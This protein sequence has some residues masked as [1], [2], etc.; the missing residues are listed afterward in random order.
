M[1]QSKL[2]KPRQLDKGP[3]FFN[4][5]DFAAKDLK[6]LRHPHGSST[7]F[8]SGCL[9]MA[10]AKNLI[11]AHPLQ[12]QTGLVCQPLSLPS[13]TPC[14]KPTVSESRRPARGNPSELAPAATG[15]CKPGRVSVMIS[16]AR[17]LALL[18]RTRFNLAR[19]GGRPSTA[20]DRRPPPL[21]RA[22]LKRTNGEDPA[23]STAF[24]RVARD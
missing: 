8:G 15:L 1:D 12:A 21:D 24:A 22:A 2:G 20:A 9:G 11:V 6:D 23:Q 17:S 18:N 4:A 13:T 19:G 10:P 7:R 14:P 3:I 5:R 16:L